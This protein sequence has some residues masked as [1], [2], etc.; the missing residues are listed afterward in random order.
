M[1][2]FAVLVIFPPS[3][4][5]VKRSANVPLLF[6][7]NAGLS[8]ISTLAP[9][10]MV[11]A[12]AAMLLGRTVPLVVTVGSSFMST[13]PPFVMVTGMNTVP[14]P[15]MGEPTE[16]ET[17]LASVT[18]AGGVVVSG[19]V[20]VAGSASAAGHMAMSSM[21]A[22][23]SAIILRF[24]FVYLPVYCLFYFQPVRTAPQARRLWRAWAA[25]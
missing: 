23:K 9:A 6:V 15:T 7:L 10:G 13:P 18:G 14:V 20:V 2:I 12:S 17:F 5:N 4:V 3:N 19:G 22:V 21:A 1:V 24:I 11:T 16:T 8:S 25:G